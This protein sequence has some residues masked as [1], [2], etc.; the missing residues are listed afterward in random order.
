MEAIK[1]ITP[2]IADLLAVAHRLA[3]LAG[4]AILPHFRKQAEIESKGG[5][6]AFDPVTDADRAAETVMREELSRTFP[7]HGIV[8]EEYG[9][10]RPDADYC[11]TL[12]PI[13]GTRAFIMGWP[14]WGTLIGL[15]KAGSPMLGVMDQPF[16]R[17]RFWGAEGR[18]FGRSRARAMPLQT[19]A[20]PELGSAIVTTTSPDLF[21]GE[22]HE[23]FEAI[24][25]RARMRRFG[26]DC[27]AYCLLAAGFTDLIVEAGLKS[28]DIAPLIPIIEGAGGVVTTWD[29]ESAA[30]G[31]RIVAAGDPALHAQAVAMLSG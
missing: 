20:C 7:S 28:Y 24:S 31:G 8:G 30:A 21:V 9:T 2:A 1:I 22:E 6:L 11:W 5:D 10:D 14:L 19:R 23:R 27:Y 4:P 26:G 29:G 13:D 12:D 16:T 18:A 15:G 3:D 25:A 17:E